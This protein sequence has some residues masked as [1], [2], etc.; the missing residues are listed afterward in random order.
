MVEIFSLYFSDVIQWSDSSLD[1]LFP[2]HHL[3][4]DME[5]P[6]Q[7]TQG[8]TSRYSNAYNTDHKCPCFKRQLCRD[9][10]SCLFNI[11]AFL[12][13]LF[14]KYKGKISGQLFY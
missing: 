10:N 12:D 9:C 3:A 5:K 7:D 4:H 13:P 11:Y 6:K 1:P 14:G 2:R 8:D